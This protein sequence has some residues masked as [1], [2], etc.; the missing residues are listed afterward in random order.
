METISITD[1]PY[2]KNLLPNRLFNSASKYVQSLG[3]RI[4]DLLT[5]PEDDSLNL[6]THNKRQCMDDRL[7]NC[8]RCES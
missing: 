7:E 2:I 5:L 6:L 8:T 4:K 3:L 1:I